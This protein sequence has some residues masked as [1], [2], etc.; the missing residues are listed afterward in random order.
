MRTA[1]WGSHSAGNRAGAWVMRA[2]MA[3]AGSADRRP[4]AGF[5]GGGLVEHRIDDAVA[6][7]VHGELRV[8]PAVD[9]RPLALLAAA[10]VQP[11]A[12]CAEPGLHLRGT[13]PALWQ[14]DMSLELCA[15]DQQDV[16]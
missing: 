3:L 13:E 15:I 2:V 11:F 12:G 6:L 16:G 10:R 8:D 9:R 5:A 1:D 14:G 4:G 7:E